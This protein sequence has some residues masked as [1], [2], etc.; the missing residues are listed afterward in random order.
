MNK[1][2]LALISTLFLTACG[3]ERLPP[4]LP[5]S[6][7]ASIKLAEA[8]DSV[9]DSLQTLEGIK[10]A[11]M[12]AYRKKLPDPGLY[13]MSNPATLDWTGPIGPLVKEIASLSGFG[14]RQLG[15]PPSIPVIVA[16]HKVDTPLGLI[17]RDADYQ[18]G[19]KADVVV[20]PRTRI[21]EL[22]YKALS[23]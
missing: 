16:I 4:P 12:P 7:P 6:D 10:K 15:N 20:Y 22:R 19:E 23:S 21:I 13:G 11:E 3:T 5:N 2:T 17:L 8:A 9:N 14:F 1:T 18:A